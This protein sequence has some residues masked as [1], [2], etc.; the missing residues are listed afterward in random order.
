MSPESS[1]WK[2]FCV[3]AT[4]YQSVR[5]TKKGAKINTINIFACVN[6]GKTEYSKPKRWKM[7]SYFKVF[8]Q[9]LF[10]LTTVVIHIFSPR[11]KHL[12]LL[13]LSMAWPVA[14]KLSYF[15]IHKL[16]TVW[17]GGRR[18]LHHPHRHHPATTKGRAGRASKQ[19]W[20]VKGEG[21]GQLG[22]D[23]AKA[24]RWLPME[25]HFWSNK[26]QSRSLF[27]TLSQ[28]ITPISFIKVAGG[29][30]NICEVP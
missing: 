6:N 23:M 8:Q 26:L 13:I 5:W 14:P 18:H 29:F 20:E 17:P 2:V 22:Q 16:E 1:A 3:P 28:V 15:I 24:G 30:T 19:M 27:P 10:L 7:F 12:Q 11:K 9:P 4:L 25:R 21:H